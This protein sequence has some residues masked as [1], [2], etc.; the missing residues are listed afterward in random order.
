MGIPTIY[1][2]TLNI[3]T[4]K[5]H[6]SQKQIQA[7]NFST[8]VDKLKFEGINE[9]IYLDKIDISIQGMRK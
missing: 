5:E 8:V 7:N 4:K 9:T 6:R 3:R 2:E 1:A